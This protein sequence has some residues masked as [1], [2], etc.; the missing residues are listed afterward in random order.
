MPQHFAAEKKSCLWLHHKKGMFKLGKF[1]SPCQDIEQEGYG[2][3]YLLNK[4]RHLWN[5]VCKHLHLASYQPQ[6]LKCL[7]SFDKRK[8]RTTR[9]QEPVQF[10]AAPVGNVKMEFEMASSYQQRAMYLLKNQNIED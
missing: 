6:P 1:C 5:A 8:I 4:N 9:S 3:I 10:D 2:P 7:S